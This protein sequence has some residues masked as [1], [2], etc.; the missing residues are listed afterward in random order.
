[1]NYRIVHITHYSYARPVSLCYNEARLLPRG[2]LLQ[3][4]PSA[5]LQIDPVPREYAEREDFFGNRVGYFAIQQPHE[6]LTIT[7][8]SEVA[9]EAQPD[10]LERCNEVAWDQVRERLLTDQAEEAL[11]ARAFRLDSPLVDA[12]GE[13]AR[14]ASPSFPPGRALAEAVHELME[15]IYHEFVYDPE[16]TTVATPLAEVLK[17]RRGVCQDFAHLA[18]GCLR[19]QGL[20]ARYVSGYLETQPPPG[21]PKL[22]G[23]DASHAWFSVYIPDTGWID[24]DPTNNQMP[25]DRHITTAWGRDYSDVTPLKGVIFGGGDEHR[26]SVSVDVA[27]LTTQ[28]PEG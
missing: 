3:N 19:A 28:A 18:I 6:E 25:M 23:A 12:S 1:M 17:H 2:S 13:L 11:E 10:A 24:F 9:V 26:L 16:F 15:R 8:T 4:C 5:R 27:N 22:V 20:A 7:A 14:Y 21:Q